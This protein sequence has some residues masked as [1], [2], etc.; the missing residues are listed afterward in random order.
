MQSDFPE[1]KTIQ[2]RESAS[3]E[4]ELAYQR[5]LEI[6]FTQRG[7]HRNGKQQELQ[8]VAL[9]KAVFS[10]P[11]AALESTRRRIELLEN[12]RTPSMDEVAEVAALRRFEESLQAI[13]DRRFSKFQR[14]VEHLQSS[15]FAWR[16][17]DPSDRLVIFSE[18][19]ETLTRL[20][21]ILP[22]A[23]GLKE[24]GFQLLHGGM[25]DTEQQELVDRFGRREDDVRV[26]LCSD[27]ASEGLNLHYFC[28]RLIH[29]DLPWSLMVFQQ[30]NGRV[31][32]YGQSRQ[33]LITYLFT[34]TTV[35][36]VKGDLR[37]LE[38][39]QAKDDQAY[40][41][42][43]D[44]ASFL[45][46]Y[47]PEKESAKVA[48]VMATGTTAEQFDAQLTA[49]A[50]RSGD[51]MGLDS[52]G[53]GDWLLQLFASAEATLANQSTV[54][55]STD[56]ISEPPTLFGGDGTSGDYFFA[57]TALQQLSLSTPIAHFS[58]DDTGQTVTLTA[59]MDLQERLK[60]TLPVEARDPDHRYSVSAIREHVLAAIEQARQAKSEDESW[61]T[62]H[63]LWPQH[64]ILEWLSDRVLTAFGRHRAPVIKCAR[65]GTGQSAYILLGLIPN[66]KGQP[67]L[68]DWQVAIHTDSAWHLESFPGFIQRM[69]LRAGRLPNPSAEIDTTG[70]QSRL[71]DAVATM[72]EHMVQLEKSFSTSMQ[73]RLTQTL[74]DLE[75][76]QARQQ[77]QLELRLAANQ[78]SE[79]FKRS[80]RE[81]RT[82]HIRQVFD[83][84][85]Q[86][87]HDTMTTE[88]QPFLQVLAAIN[89]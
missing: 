11:W 56:F 57:K 14:L 46:V 15:E 51:G 50:A 19:I 73:V 8:R 85:R 31:D 88:P 34:S 78:Q 77:Q 52:E 70:L 36:R 84:Y 39:L 65:L 76:L 43:G 74:A 68:V 42:L 6:P 75:I 66:R 17:S 40:K 81:K 82:L 28:H 80:R 13:P 89:P 48:E 45:N 71:P 33:P 64:P 72:R 22:A 63:Y 53:A 86:W 35:P 54:R 2:L 25:T 4:E 37:I 10:S 83:E 9:Q 59:P 55:P 61:P 21:F 69:E 49:T 60:V 16:P 67:L 26:L 27:V 18:R 3:L 30:R 47:D 5:L 79:Q 23:L 7:E 38:I 24:S 1:R 32:R 20:K 44:P 62:L 58:T 29:F 41:N 87:V 12:E